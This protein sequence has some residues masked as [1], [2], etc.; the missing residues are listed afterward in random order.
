MEWI[1]VHSQ[2]ELDAA[3]KAGKGANVVGN[4]TVT[5]YGNSTV[6]ACD[7]ST[8]TASDNSTVRAY[9]LAVVRVWSATATITATPRVTV[10]VAPE[11]KPKITGGVVVRQSSHPKS[12]KD[13]CEDFG[14]EVSRGTA[15]LF[16]G[17]QADFTSPHNLSYAPG[18]TPVAPDWD[19]GTREC[20]GGL[21]FSPH[22]TLTHRY[23]DD[24]KHYVRCPVKLT[25][26][27]VHVRADYPDKVKAPK[28]C[29]PVEECDI[30]GKP[31]HPAPSKK[32]ATKKRKAK[33][34]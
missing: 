5:A 16:K 6:T 20:G 18:T 22:P 34:K 26:I 4:S 3:T 15:Y 10:I 27:A 11:I 28:C 31:L 33:K 9:W 12:A 2:A 14:V 30:D 21:H 29:G 19:G 25:D 1:D 32:P 8:V 7:N 13:W 24:P 23:I 17:L